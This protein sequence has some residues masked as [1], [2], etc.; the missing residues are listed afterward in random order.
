MSNYFPDS[1]FVEYHLLK[2]DYLDLHYF[3]DNLERKLLYSFTLN[4]L[5]P[6]QK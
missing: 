3:P 4:L 1:V 2:K 5:F 6:R